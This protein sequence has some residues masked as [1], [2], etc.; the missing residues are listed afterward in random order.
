MALL[1]V[2]QQEAL[3]LRPKYLKL[4]ENARE[5]KTKTIKCTL[6]ELSHTLYFEDNIGKHWFIEEKLE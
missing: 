1:H 4:N 5:V 6:Y 3:T 2:L